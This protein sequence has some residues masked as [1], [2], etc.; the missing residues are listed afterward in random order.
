MFVYRITGNDVYRTTDIIAFLDVPIIAFLHGG[1]DR[2]C[3]ID[4]AKR[5]ADRVKQGDKGVRVM[6]C[7]DH[8]GDHN[9]LPL[10]PKFTTFIDKFVSSCEC[11]TYTYTRNTVLPRHARKEGRRQHDVGDGERDEQSRDR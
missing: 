11:T 10:R 3:S 8:W 7:W 4:G 2:R 1:K 9:D 5:M 6:T